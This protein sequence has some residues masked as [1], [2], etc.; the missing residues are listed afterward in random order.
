MTQNRSRMQRNALF[1]WEADSYVRQE[2]RHISKLCACLSTP[3]MIFK[4]PQATPPS[5]ALPPNKSWRRETEQG[6]R[7]TSS[8]CTGQSA[9]R[10]RIEAGSLWDAKLCI[11]FWEVEI[12]MKQ[13]SFL[14]C[15][16]TSMRQRLNEDGVQTCAS[17]TRTEWQLTDIALEQVRLLPAI[18]WH[19]SDFK[20][21]F[22]LLNNE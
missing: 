14:C 18:S 20:A 8:P 19:F 3:F 15:D 6:G 4:M 9:R 22:L 17:N 13:S 7:K 21:F 1:A 16:L 11:P 2:G 10:T 12:C 5:Q